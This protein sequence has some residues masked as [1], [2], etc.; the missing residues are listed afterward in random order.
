VPLDPRPFDAL[1]KQVLGP[2]F[3][4]RR[5]PRSVLHK[6][7]HL[8][9]AHIGPLV[10]QLRAEVHT[11]DETASSLTRQP[12]I[13]R[14]AKRLKPLTE[15]F[16]QMWPFT[17]RT[18]D[19]ILACELRQMTDQL[20]TDILQRQRPT[21]GGVAKTGSARQYAT[22]AHGVA[23]AMLDMVFEAKADSRRSPTIVAK[24]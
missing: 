7:F 18:F 10:E 11:I 24:L 3:F 2:D 22:I 16:G 20:V 12:Q 19:I 8:E 6:R 17:R 21:R 4:D 14:W 15:V 13:R 23:S 1:L 5:A 9:Y